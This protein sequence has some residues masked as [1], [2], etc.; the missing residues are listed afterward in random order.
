VSRTRPV[1]P[2][3]LIVVFAIA[4]IGILAGGSWY[5]LRDGRDVPDP[6]PDPDIDGPSLPDYSQY[7][8]DRVH[9]AL[10]SRG[11]LVIA[12]KKYRLRPG[13]LPASL[14]D[15]I[16]QPPELPPTKVW[17]GPYISTIGLLSDSW[18]QRYRYRAPGV[19]LPEGYDLWSI[20]PDG[21]DN[22][23]DDIGNW[24]VP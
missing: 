3:A 15:L 24:S 2:T 13:G 17:D 14:D 12:I 6:D 21:R 1:R 10:G 9:R 18:G 5:M 16:R 8:I 4:L 20:G 19:H 7:E 22:T 23:A 11:L